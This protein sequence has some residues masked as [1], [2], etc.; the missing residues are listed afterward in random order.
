MIV[1][2]TQG[3][4]N[5]KETKTAAH[6]HCRCTGYVRIRLEGLRS[7]FEQCVTYVMST[8]KQGDKSAQQLIEMWKKRRK[9]VMWLMAQI[10]MTVKL[11]KQRQIKH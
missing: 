1:V 9:G 4:V 10:R 5:Q 11:G 6:Y 3:E 2:E 7:S 8:N